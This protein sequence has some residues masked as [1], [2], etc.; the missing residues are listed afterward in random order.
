MLLVVASEPW[1]ELLLDFAQKYF[2][3][4]ERDVIDTGCKLDEHWFDIL[5]RQVDRTRYLY[6]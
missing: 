2:I 6:V 5:V 4:S 3:F 1:F